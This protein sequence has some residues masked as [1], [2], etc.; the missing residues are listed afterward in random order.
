MKKERV[1]R[2]KVISF[3]RAL[4]K[5]KLCGGDKGNKKTKREKTINVTNRDSPGREES[6]EGN[7]KMFE[8]FD[9]ALDLITAGR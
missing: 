5:N 9:H 3:I 7:G 6:G 4:D 2:F 8:L 1:T